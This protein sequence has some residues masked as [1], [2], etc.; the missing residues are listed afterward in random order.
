MFKRI[1]LTKVIF[2]LV[3]VLGL[4]ATTFAM[5]YK[6]G[7]Y[8]V[9]VE[10]RNSA[11]N[12]IPKAKVRLYLN[13]SSSN[14]TSI[15]VKGT[16]EGYKSSKKKITLFPNQFFYKS[17]LELKDV[18][19]KIAIIDL[20]QDIISSAYARTDQ[21]GFP[22]D[23]FG[24]TIFI[25]KVDWTDATS[26]NVDVIEPFWGLPYK[27]TC[28]IKEV[29]QFYQ[30]SI[31][32][33]RKALEWGGGELIVV[34]RTRVPNRPEVLDLKI[35][36]LL[37]IPAGK[38]RQIACVKLSEYLAQSYSTKELREKY[39]VLPEPLESMVKRNEK[40]TQLH[41]ENF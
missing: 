40:F 25:P 21:F 27:K 10:V 30:V 36:K 28:E 29:D 5:P 19:T 18:K 8:T 37:D 38:N 11:M 17:D 23:K 39:P 41:G 12:I 20:N 34:F 13:G 16:A 9:D 4:T 6:I 15:T 3:L 22:G 14:Y 26:K 24:M 31:G 1:T 2:I 33:P 32:I 7:K 35:A